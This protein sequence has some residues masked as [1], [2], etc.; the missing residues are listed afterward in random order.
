MLKSIRLTIRDDT[1]NSTAAAAAAAAQAGR[2][3]KMMKQAGNSKA[4]QPV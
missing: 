2:P 3:A 4:E 1:T